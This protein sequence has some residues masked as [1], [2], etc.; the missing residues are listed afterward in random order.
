MND[1]LTAVDIQ[2]MQDEIKYRQ[3]E[4]RPKILEDVKTAREFGDLN[5]RRPSRKSAVTTAASAT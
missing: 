3:L 2:K 1:E 4:L 5:I